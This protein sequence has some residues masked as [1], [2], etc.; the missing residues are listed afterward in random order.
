LPNATASDALAER[1]RIGRE[2]HDVLAHSPDTLSVQLN[3]ADAALKN[4]VDA[5]RLP[6][7]LQQ[8]RRLTVKG[9]SETPGLR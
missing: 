2:E 9:L 5:A 7:L 1:D 4:G 6:P 3:A 8:A